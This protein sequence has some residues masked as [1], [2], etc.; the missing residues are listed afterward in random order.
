MT[1]KMKFPYILF[2]SWIQISGETSLGL[3]LQIVHRELSSYQK[4]LYSEGYWQISFSQAP[5]EISP[6]DLS[7]C[8]L[9]IHSTSIPIRFQ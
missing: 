9:P 1:A 5:R 4:Y 3:P 7:C 2:L 6:W 8:R